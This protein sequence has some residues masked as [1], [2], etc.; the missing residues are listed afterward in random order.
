[1]SFDG[2]FE[3]EVALYNKRGEFYDMGNSQ[4]VSFEK[5]YIVFL[6]YELNEQMDLVFKG[7]RNINEFK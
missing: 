6:K 7:L 2:E 3:I 4:R 5:N 1:M